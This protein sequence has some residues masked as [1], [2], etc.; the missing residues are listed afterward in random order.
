MWEAEA[1]LG[2]NVVLTS[3]TQLS[4]SAVPKKGLSRPCTTTLGGDPRYSTQEILAGEYGVSCALIIG[5][6]KSTD[7]K[8]L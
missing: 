7:R 5:Q 1:V 4:M 3:S 2:A 8:H 6:R